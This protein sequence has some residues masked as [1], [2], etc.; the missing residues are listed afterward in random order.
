M[1][2]L[3][4]NE[5]S[6]ILPL[7]LLLIVVILAYFVGFHWFVVRHVDYASVYIIAFF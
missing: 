1:K 7:G 3:P 2:L 6:K 4:E 5:N